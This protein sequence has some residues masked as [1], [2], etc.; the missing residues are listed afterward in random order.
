[1]KVIKSAA[2][3]SII[4]ASLYASVA[5]ADP[6]EAMYSS[7]SLRAVETSIPEYPRRAQ[8]IGVE[9][10]SVVEFTVMP[11][12]TVAEPAIAE[13]N[14]RLFSRAALEAIESWKFEPVVAD[15]GEAIPVRSAMKFSFVGSEQ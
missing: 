5:H 9:G 10:Y 7:K 13:T 11:D 3:L 2:A 1:M 12:G 8:M 4:A 6:A 14:S 15:A